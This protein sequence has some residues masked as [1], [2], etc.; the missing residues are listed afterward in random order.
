MRVKRLL[1]LFTIFSLLIGLVGCSTSQSKKEGEEKSKDQAQQIVLKAGIGSSLQNSSHG[2]GLV[3]FQEIV[4]KESNGRIRLQIFPDGQLGNDKSMMEALQMGTL[5]ITIPSTAPIANFTKSFMV[6]DL[7]YLFPNEEVADRVLDGPAG[8]DILKTLEDVGMVGLAYWEN[9]FRNITNSKRPINSIDDLKGLKIRT[10]QN[11]IHLETF[12]AW[13]ANP[14][15]MPFNE[16]FTALEQKVIDGQENPN[17]LIYDAGFYE[18]Q[19]YLTLSR[20]F[21]TPFVF[22]ISKKTWDKLSPA[23]QELLKKA[24]VEAGKYQ[25]QINRELS[26]KYLE[27]MKKKGIAVNELS[28]E[29][30][31]KFIEKSRTIYAKFENEI[32]KDR[33]KKVLDEIAKVQ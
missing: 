2:K 21:Y 14:V 8:Q 10:M 23:D 12:K 9:G 13:G 32:G 19:K 33:L 25:R 3:K 11:P 1:L 24:A 20:H 22:M 26:E 18:A 27:E 7:P 6:F 31:Q 17:T 30:K 28:T 15:P 5:D 4:E 16:V 29:E